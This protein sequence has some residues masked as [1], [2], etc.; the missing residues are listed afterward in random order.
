MKY[1]WRVGLMPSLV[2]VGVLGGLMAPLPS[3]ALNST[4][5]SL[6]IDGVLVNNM[7]RIPNVL[8]NG[9]SVCP[10]PDRR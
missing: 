3:E 5:P 1:L 8:V 10:S 2:L 4:M 6:T 7:V 9:V